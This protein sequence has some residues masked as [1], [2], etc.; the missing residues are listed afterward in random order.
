MSLNLKTKISFLKDKIKERAP[1]IWTDF[2]DQFKGP[3]KDHWK[4]AGLGVASVAITT[5]ILLGV[6]FAT[7]LLF[8]LS[9]ATMAF[10]SGSFLASSRQRTLS[11]MAPPKK[12]TYIGAR[13]VTLVAVAVSFYS[14][15]GM[16]MREVFNNNSCPPAPKMEE[17][18]VS[19]IPA[20]VFT[21]GGTR[22][23]FS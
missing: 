20:G 3:A 15:S 8:A 17:R 5:G 12:L 7:S 18:A 13:V 1:K 11:V 14:I 21:S 2:K 10:I 16:R 19:K 23:S 9:A 22:Y 6:L 4:S